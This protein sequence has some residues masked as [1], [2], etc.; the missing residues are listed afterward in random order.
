MKN[1]MRILTVALTVVLMAAAFVAPASATC[2][3]DSLEA[4]GQKTWM[5]YQADPANLPDVEDGIV[6][7]GEY[8]EPIATAGPT[9]AGVTIS[10]WTEEGPNPLDNE[11][12]L[13]I[14]PER[15]TMYATFDEEFLYMALVVIKASHL[16]EADTLEAMWASWEV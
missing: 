1:A 10:N 13:E 7:D 16:S 11:T 8:G 2:A 3:V 12:L 15:M 6:S 9:D 5:V 4:Y 14:A